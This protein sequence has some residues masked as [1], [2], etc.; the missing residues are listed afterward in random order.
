MTF[1]DNRISSYEIYR[2]KYVGAK[3]FDY[4][5]IRNDDGPVMFGLIV[6]ASLPWPSNKSDQI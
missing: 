2:R 3:T 1:G 5:Y 6:S 4:L